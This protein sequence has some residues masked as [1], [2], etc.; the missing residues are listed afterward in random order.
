MMANRKSSSAT[1]PSSVAG[2]PASNQ[3][4]DCGNVPCDHHRSE[5]PPGGIC[6]GEACLCPGFV[7]R[8][9]LG[10]YGRGDDICWV[11]FN[12]QRCARRVTVEIDGKPFC[13]AHGAA[14]LESLR[15][16]EPK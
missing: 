13:R 6:M 4:D 9:R 14:A 10:P 7:P 12:G 2:V 11:I 15:E 3:K 5:H 16:A 1:D 8:S